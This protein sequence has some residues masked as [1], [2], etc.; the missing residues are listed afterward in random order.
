MSYDFTVFRA[1]KTVPMSLEEIDPE[2]LP[3]MGDY[4]DVKRLLDSHCPGIV[5]RDDRRSG[6]LENEIGRFEFKCHEEILMLG[7]FG[8]GMSFRQDLD[9]S[10]AFLGKLL[11]S[12]GLFAFDDQSMEIIGG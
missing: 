12:A 5:W 3:P 9:S 2:A 7:S 11:K 10:L 1:G 4:E 8:I 6:H